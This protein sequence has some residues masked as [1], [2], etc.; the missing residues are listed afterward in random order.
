MIIFK[1]PFITF[2]L[3]TIVIFFTAVIIVSLN[4]NS[5]SDEL[6]IRFNNTDGVKAFG[7]KT[8]LLGILA[9]SAFML[10]LNFFLGEKLF[11]RDRVL[12]AFFLASNL[13]ISILSLVT[14]SL[15]ISIN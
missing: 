11:Y 10:I 5:V 2:S 7:T 14:T 4:F 13:L 9:I 8:D 15:L 1:K 6:I 3:V 12:T